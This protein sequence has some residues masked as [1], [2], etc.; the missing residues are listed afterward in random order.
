MEQH[1]GDS[2]DATVERIR[3]AL[4]ECVGVLR[5]LPAD[6]WQATGQH[7]SRGP[8]T[9]D[10]LF[11]AFLSSHAAEHA[12]QTQATLQALRATPST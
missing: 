9:V 2:L 11:E 3:A 12:S 10:E 8:M 6:A 5:S 1:G 7:P 4:T